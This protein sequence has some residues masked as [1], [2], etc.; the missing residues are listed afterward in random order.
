LYNH[1]HRHSAIGF[2]TP[3]QRHAGLDRALFEERALVYERAPARKI[4]N[5]GQGKLASGCMSMSFTSTEKPH[6]SRSL[7]THKKQPDS[8]HF[9]RQLP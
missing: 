5:A 3:A 2:V 9:R 8:L 7:N 6:K 4:L 1:Q